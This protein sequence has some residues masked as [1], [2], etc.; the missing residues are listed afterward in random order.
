MNTYYLT[1][2]ALSSIILTAVQTALV[3]VSPQSK[4]LS[5]REAWSAFGRPNVER[6]VKNGKIAPVRS[7]TKI[8]CKRQYSRLELT[9]LHESEKVIK[10]IS[11]K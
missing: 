5:Q 3:A 2:S 4:Y 1:E 6:W 9:T 10:V 11:Q 8:N 7:G